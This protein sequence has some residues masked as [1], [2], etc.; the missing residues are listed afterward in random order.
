MD[1]LDIELMNYQND[2]E[3]R[4]PVCHEYNDEDWTCDCCYECE[5]EICTCNDEEE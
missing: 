5:N 1:Y 2:Q 3:S 4:C